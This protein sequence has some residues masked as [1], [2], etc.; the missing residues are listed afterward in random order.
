MKNEINKIK[1]FLKNKASTLCEKL[2]NNVIANT[3][4]PCT[5]IFG[6]VPSRRLG[7]SLGVNN[8]RCKICTYDCIYCQVGRT[9][10]CSTC[11]EPCLSPYELFCFVKKKLQ[12]LEAKE[13]KV[14][15]ISFVPN[16]EPTIDKS[17]GKNIHILREFGYKIAVFTNSSLLWNDNV[18]ENLLF[19]DYISVKV[20]SVNDK[21]WQII[22]RPHTRLNLDII[23]KGI[24]DFAK[25]YNGKL[26]TET[27]L[28]K[29]INDNIQEIEQV[30]NFLKKFRSDK[31]YFTIPTRPPTESFATAPDR[32]TLDQLS[33]YIEKNIPNS[34]T[35][36]SP[37][38][39]SFYAAGEIEDE[40]L[41]ITRVHPMR[42]ESLLK[43]IKDMGGNKETLLQ[44]IIH[45]QLQKI[46]YQDKFFYSTKDNN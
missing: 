46:F 45:N 12:K 36:F 3:G 31:S 10:C 29:N 6:P 16:G 25:I 5:I 32:K 43:L 42:E 4:I 27:M 33:D 11:C 13:I 19:A 15:Y 2:E 21:T 41:G 30:G 14:D 18:K 44:M 22:N 35:L 9:T 7:L 8:M 34:E 1:Y 26:T 40:I 20:D 38:S 24:I 37:E 39:N 28:V 17:L 23:L